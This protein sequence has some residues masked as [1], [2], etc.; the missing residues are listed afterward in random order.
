MALGNNND[1][2]ARR[3]NKQFRDLLQTVYNKKSYFADFSAGGIETLDGIQFN[4]TAFSLKTSDIPTVLGVY[5]TG[6]AVAFGAGTSN[7]NRFGNRTEIIY[8]DIDVPYE[9]PWALHEGIDRFTVN[10]DLDAAVADRLVLA[11][12]AQTKRYDVAMATALNT[13]K[14]ATEAL[15]GYT[16]AA[17]I[18][19]FNNLSKKYIDLEVD[20][21]NVV[22]KVGADLY[23]AIVN[24][25]LTTT[26]KNSTVN[27]D[28]NGITRFKGFIIEPVP[29]NTLPAGVAALVFPRG[30]GKFFVGINTVRTVESEDFDG[31]ALQGAG[32]YGS[33][34]LPDNKPAIVAV[35]E[36]VPGP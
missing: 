1:L 18:T 33:Y 32:K 34:V 19:L 7:T 20:T 25:T 16:D 5:N 36:P 6:A 2:A 26:G 22:A 27:I 12:Q 15:G 30:I 17:I 13:N 28:A 8:S 31:V 10:N 3:Y 14:G 35:T 4:A 11:A 24:G 29:S 21:A 9:A 23:N